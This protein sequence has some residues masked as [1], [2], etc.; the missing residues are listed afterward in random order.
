MYQIYKKTIIYSILILIMLISS[1]DLKGINANISAKL[2]YYQAKVEEGGMTFE[3]LIPF[4]DTIIYIYAENNDISNQIR[5]MIKKAEFANN[6]GNR[7]KAFHLYRD[8]IFKLNQC[9]SLSMKEERKKC[10]YDIAR[11]ALD[12][13][14]LDE[15]A[16]YVFELLKYV[17]NTDLNY[18]ARSY[19]MLGFIFVNLK[20]LE[21]S[22]DYN[23]KALDIIRN[24]DTISA[25]TSYS[26][27]NSYVGLLFTKRQYDS[28]IKYLTEAKKYIK[29]IKDP[30]QG[31]NI[32]HNFAIIYEE[33]GELA[34]A[35]EYYLKTLEIVDHNEHLHL[36]AL[37]YF[38]L[39]RL[40]DKMGDTENALDYHEKA[41]RV[42]TKIGATQI[43]G[44]ALIAISEL[45]YDKQDYKK[46]R[47][48][49]ELGRRV[50]D[51]VF[52]SQNIERISILTNNFETQNEKMEK[53]L[54]RQKI[55]LSDLKRNILIT[56]LL[57][58]ILVAIIVSLKLI[59]QRTANKALN[60]TISALKQKNKQYEEKSKYKFES[61][62]DVKNK[63]LTSTTL[64]LVTANEIIE[65]IREHIEEAKTQK[66]ET[67]KLSSIETIDKLIKSY[68]PEH[69]K[70]EFRLYFEQVQQSFFT[71]LNETHPHLSYDDQRICALIILNLSAKE[72]ANITNKSIRTVETNIYHIRKNMNIPAKIK[73]VSYLRQFVD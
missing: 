12:L 8:I 23:N 10:M 32:Y 61:I 30:S 73:T 45:Y 5:F 17:N 57:I 63:E 24:V 38:N 43:R 7:V 20:K 13:G 28:A 44:N 60:K 54:M 37:T 18:V 58:I 39:A 48:L 46:S 35:K 36:T 2:N 31:H 42:A 55:A 66:N 11:T 21:K 29:A 47:D 34:V 6:N 70:E 69:G 53:E 1:I 9:D 4:Y 68:N 19:S 16:T 64:S 22:E 62:I 71:K 41:L 65:N 67:K 25:L 14:M 3:K 50:R 51:S 49:L 56:I 15:S 40:Y 72:I 26:V 59:K 27:Y 33:I 52:N